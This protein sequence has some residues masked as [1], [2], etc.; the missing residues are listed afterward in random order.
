MAT[1]ATDTS[2]AQAAPPRKKK[3][4]TDRARSERRTAWLLCA[5]AV[6]VMLLVTG[7]PIVY[8]FILS[9]QKYDLRFPGQKEF[10]GL[11]NYADV[12][13]SSTWWTD[14]INTVII[15]VF[16]VSIEL[17][18]GMLIA[19]VMHRAIF[20]RGAVRTAVLIP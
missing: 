11:S 18:L 5:P 17:V 13:T 2:Q 1:A 9:L 15:T 12:L 14:V 19:L 6:I 3:G 20:G 8:A 16:S 4:L 7:Y 10:V